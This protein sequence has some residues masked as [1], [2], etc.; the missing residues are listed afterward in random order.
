MMNR[1]DRYAGFA[2]N[3]RDGRY[4]EIDKIQERLGSDSPARTL[5]AMGHP[6]YSQDYAMRALAMFVMRP[7]LSIHQ[8][9]IGRMP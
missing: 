2:S 3:V 1:E 7:D 5:N 9:V 4:A 8:I 6:G